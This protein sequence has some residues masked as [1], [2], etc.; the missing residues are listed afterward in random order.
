MHIKIGVQAEEDDWPDCFQNGTPE[1]YAALRK[2]IDA[3]KAAEQ[4]K[5]VEMIKA[6]K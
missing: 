5:R 1:R 4:A 3:R 6:E 2:K